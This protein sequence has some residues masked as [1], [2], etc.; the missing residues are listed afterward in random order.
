MTPG[1]IG[2]ARAGRIPATSYSQKSKS[3]SSV[4][5]KNFLEPNR[6]QNASMVDEG[7]QFRHDKNQLSEKSYIPLRC[8]Q[9]KEVPTNSQGRFKYEINL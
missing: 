1:F 4:S 5:R 7:F 8:T 9:N 3:A 6:T 2:L